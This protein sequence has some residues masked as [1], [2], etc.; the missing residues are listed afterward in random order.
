MYLQYIG[1][2]GLR[3]LGELC[4]NFMISLFL[5]NKAD[6]NYDHHFQSGV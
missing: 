2:T 3:L 5:S 6:I 1:V 4:D